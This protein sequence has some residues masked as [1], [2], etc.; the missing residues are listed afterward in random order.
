MKPRILTDAEIEANLDFA[1]P[2]AIEAVERALLAKA[3]G[4]LMAPPRFSLAVDNGALVFT[5]GAETRYA[6]AIGF[7]VYDTF[8][9]NTPEHTQMVAV[10]DAED[11]RLKGLALGD[12]VGG[13]RTAAINA[14][15][16]KQMA[17]P[18][19][20]VLGL[21]GAGF[22]ARFHLLAAMA[23]HPFRRVSIYSRT[24]DRLET[25]AR[26]MEPLIDHP[27]HL[28]ASAREVVSEADVLVC[29]TN[30]RSPI[31]DAGWL[32][33]GV[34]I[35]TIGPKFVDAHELPVDAAR[36][37][38]TIVT[39]SLAQVDAYARPFFLPDPDRARMG[40]L[41]EVV[42]GRLAGRLSDEGV[43][44]F[45]SVGLAGTEVVVADRLLTLIG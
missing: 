18:D 36:R 39:D 35:N 17:R 41:S 3:E 43:T 42:A 20:A 44:L 21:L 5:T 24:R 37:A 2:Q 9:A 27:L 7:R 22:Q 25:F 32:R 16:I 15:A 28:A 8:P 10:Y 13:L 45:C 33:P 4:G 26:A 6:R 1:V 31:F 29:A 38:E 34:H 23:A 40:E 19:A 12:W 30:S 11:G 14:V